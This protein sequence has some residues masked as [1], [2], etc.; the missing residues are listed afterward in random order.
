MSI[1]LE[2]NESVNAGFWQFTVTAHLSHGQSHPIYAISNSSDMRSVLSSLNLWRH[3]IHLEEQSF[4]SCVRGVSGWWRARCPFWIRQMHR[5]S[6]CSQDLWSKL[7]VNQSKLRIQWQPFSFRRKRH[8][9]EIPCSRTTMEVALWY[10]Q[11]RGFSLKINM[12]PSLIFD[13]LY[14]IYVLC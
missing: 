5:F 2:A 9:Q 1:I 11:I 3:C 14:L 6:V 8:G 12:I 10:C 7:K 13:F 4:W